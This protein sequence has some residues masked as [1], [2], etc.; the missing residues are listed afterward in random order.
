MTHR[1]KVAII[2][3]AFGYTDFTLV[4]AEE[5]LNDKDFDTRVQKSLES[6]IDDLGEGENLRLVVYEAIVDTT[7]SKEVVIKQNN[8][9]PNQVSIPHKTINAATPALEV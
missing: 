6:H 1:T 5:C 7:Y 2:F 4:Q 9:L 8:V 3:D